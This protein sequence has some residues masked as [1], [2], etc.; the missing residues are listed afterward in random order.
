ML[1]ILPDYRR[2]GIGEA[3]AIQATNRHLRLGL[4]PFSQIKAGNLASLAMQKKLG[5]TV[6]DELV[7]WIF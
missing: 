7:C 3:L 2:R 4:T 5:Y 6:S 1:E